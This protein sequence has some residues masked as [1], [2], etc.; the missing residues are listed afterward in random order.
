MLRCERR[1][2]LR[3]SRLL[4]AVCFGVVV[5]GGLPRSRALCG[6]VVGTVPTLHSSM[7]TVLPL[8]GRLEDG[9]RSGESNDEG[10]QN[11][12]IGRRTLMSHVVR[13]SFGGRVN[14][15]GDNCSGVIL[16]RNV[17][18]S[19]CSWLVTGAAADL[20]MRGGSLVIL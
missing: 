16:H 20:S 7:S 5:A 12:E 4:M 17:A 15:G 10:L 6:L 11:G 9:F 1:L 8:A 18:G 19:D 2:H 14:L 13:K 3:S